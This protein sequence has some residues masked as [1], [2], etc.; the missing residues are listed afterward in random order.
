MATGTYTDNSSQILTASVTWSSSDVDIAS[1]SNATNSNGLATGLELGTVSISAVLGA[2]TS[3]AVTLTVT[4]QPERVLYSFAG[5]VDGENPNSALIQASDGNFYG[6]TPNGGANNLGTVFK[7][8]SAGVET[9]LHSFAGGSDGRTPYAAL[10]QGSDGNFYGTTVV[11][12]TDNRGTVYKIT[13][14]GVET[15]LYSFAAG[16]EGANPYA[17]L[18]QGS[19]GNFYGTTK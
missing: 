5:G 18:I 8:T 19:E 2:V 3:T 11:G 7:I 1:I 15:V 4:P 9:V 12:G 14:A 6:T 13:A 10:I 16:S 17:A